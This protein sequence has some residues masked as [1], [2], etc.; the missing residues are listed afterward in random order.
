MMKRLMMAASVTAGMALAAPASAQ[1][2]IAADTPVQGRLE[3]GDRTRDGYWIDSYSYNGEAGEEVRVYRGRPG[4]D[5]Y[6]G[7]IQVRGPG[8]FATELLGGEAQNVRLPQRGRY[9]I[10]VLNPSAYAPMDYVL[11]VFHVSAEQPPTQLQAGQTIRAGFTSTDSVHPIMGHMRQDAYTFTARAN[12]AV[13]FHIEGQRTYLYFDISG[14]GGFSR[15][16][17]A[18]SGEA[19]VFDVNFPNAGEYRVLVSGEGGSYALTLQPSTTAANAPAAGNISVG[20]TAQLAYS[21]DSPIG[22]HSAPV[23]VYTFEAQRGDR[24]AVVAARGAVIRGA[25]GER[26]ETNIVW[27]NDGRSF[28]PGDLRVVATEF[29]APATGQYRIHALVWPEMTPAESTLRLVNAAQGASLMAEAR[30]RVAGQLAER[31]VRVSQLIQQGDQLLN[32]GNNEAATAAYLEA[33][34][35]DGGNVQAMIN[36]GVAAHRQGAF[37]GAQGWFRQALELD[38]NN[39]LAAANLAA[40]IQA[41]ETQQRDQQ[42]AYAQQQREREQENAQ[43]LSNALGAFVAGANAGA[44]LEAA[45]QQP[46][47]DR[48]TPSQTQPSQGGGGASPAPPPQQSASSG[49]GGNGSESFLDPQTMQPCVRPVRNYTE[50]RSDGGTNYRWLFRNTCGLTFRVFTYFN[51]VDPSRHSGQQSNGILPNSEMTMTCVYTTYN[52]AHSCRGFA[53]YEILR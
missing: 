30:A 31:N 51:P 45:R 1:T 2:L 46:E 4:G 52:L 16:G 28:E 5:G 35:L 25:N 9:T 14:P 3:R 50:A 24:L 36:L 15:M 12:E 41:D 27:D 43:M 38:P 21:S 19:G 33:L 34:R 32:S 40:A 48:Y 11:T 8:G 29:T 13:T 20:D 23:N 6:D 53:R 49:G 47:A 37:L 39:Q 42:Q 10:S 17:H 26:V 22:E 7:Y 44:A 18:D